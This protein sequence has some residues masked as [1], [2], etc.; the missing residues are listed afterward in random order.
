MFYT[1]AAKVIADEKTLGTFGDLAK[2]L[3]INVCARLHDPEVLDGYIDPDILV[4]GLRTKE[5]E[6]HRNG[7]AEGLWYYSSD[8]QHLQ[9]VRKMISDFLQTMEKQVSLSAMVSE[10]YEF[11][12][13]VLPNQLISTNFHNFRLRALREHSSEMKSHSQRSELCAAS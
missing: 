13:V 4:L 8:K 5:T 6:R 11:T 3:G 2:K 12:N 1:F 10:V 9:D 7:E